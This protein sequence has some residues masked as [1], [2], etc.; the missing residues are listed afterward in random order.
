MDFVFRELMEDDT[1]RL[2][3]IS[4]VLDLPV[5]KIKETRLGNPFLR[6]WL[7]KMKQ[8][9]DYSD[10][11]ELHTI[12]LQKKLHGDTRLDDWI[13]LFNVRSEEEF[14]KRMRSAG[15]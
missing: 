8:G 12:E 10:L 11:L 9:N 5:E 2:Y 3:F 14:E 6:K 1:V 13:R 4:D 7:G 15:F